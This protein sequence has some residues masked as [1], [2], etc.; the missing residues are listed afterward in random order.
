MSE[1]PCNDLLVHVSGIWISMILLL[2][3][4]FYFMYYINTSIKCEK[5]FLLFD[6]WYIKGTTR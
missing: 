2:A 6:M 1:L 5:H 4:D 3:Q